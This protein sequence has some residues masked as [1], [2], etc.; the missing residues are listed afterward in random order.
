MQ[1]CL[2]YVTRPELEQ[3]A[4]LCNVHSDVQAMKLSPFMELSDSGSVASSSVSA[5]RRKVYKKRKQEYHQEK[6]RIAYEL[7][8]TLK[9]PTVVI[10]ADWLKIRGTLRKWMRV[11]CVLKPGLFIVYKN[12]KTDKLG[13]WIGTVLLSSCELIERPSKKGGFCFK[14]Y[15]AMDQSIWASRG[16]R[17]ESFG[18]VTQP[19]PTSHLICRA[20]SEESGRCWMDGLELALKCNRLLLRTLSRQLNK[21]NP[22]LD[23][24]TNE[25]KNISDSLVTLDVK[26]DLGK[27]SCYSFSRV[28]L[29]DVANLLEDETPS[30]LEEDVERAIRETP[31]VPAPPE[32]FG[33]F[34]GLEQVEEVAD[35]NKSLLWAL[36]KQVRPGMDLSKVVLPTFVLEPRSFLEKLADYY[37][38]SDLLTEAIRENDPYK[39]IQLVLKFYL[40]GFYKKPKVNHN[41]PFLR[42][43]VRRFVAYLLQGL[44]KPYNPVL[45][46]MFRCYWHSPETG[47]KTFYI[48][49]QVSHHP[50]VSA[51]FVTNR[52]AGFNIAGSILAKSKFYGNSLSAILCGNAKITLLSRGESYVVTLPYAHCKGLLIGTLTFQLGGSVCIT[53]DRTSYSAEL[54]FKLRPFLGG[55]ETINSVV[56]KVKLGKETLADINGRWDSSIHFTDRETGETSVLWA[57]TEE[58]IQQRLQRFDVDFQHQSP[59]ESQKLWMAVSEAIR[60]S[61]QTKATEEKTKIEDAQRQRARELASLGEAYEPHVFEFDSLSGQWLYRHADYRPWDSQNDVVQYESNFVI[62]TQSHHKTP[63]VKTGSLSSVHSPNYN[64]MGAS[65]EWSEEEESASEQSQETEKATA[66]TL[67]RFPI[68]KK[69][70]METLQ[71]AVM[72]I[73]KRL[74][75][76]ELKLDAL[77]RRNGLIVLGGQAV[78]FSLGNWYC[79]H[80]LSVNDETDSRQCE[81]YF[82]GT[83]SLCCNLLLLVIFEILGVLSR[84]S[85]LFFWKATL[86]AVAAMLLFFIPKTV[87]QL[88]IRKLRFTNRT[89]A[90]GL[91]SFIWLSTMYFSWKVLGPLP[92]TR[93]E[94]SIWSIENIVSRVGVIGV[95]IVAALAGFGAIS[96]LYTSLPCFAQKVPEDYADKVERQIGKTIEMIAAKKFGTFS[97]GSINERYRTTQGFL[98]LLGMGT[99]S[100]AE[101]EAFEEVKSLEAFN[102]RLFMELADINAIN[103]R[104]E[105]ARTFRGKY[106]LVLGYLLSLL[107]VWKIFSVRSA[108]SIINIVFDRYG[109]VDPVTRVIGIAVHY[110]GFDFDVKIWSQHFSFV[111][112]GCLSLSSVR[113]LLVSFAKLF[114]IVNPGRLSKIS[115][116]LTAEVMGMYLLS[117]VLLVR[118]S[119]PPEYRWII[120][121]VFGDLAYPF[122][123][124]WFDEIFILSAIASIVF[125]AIVRK[126]YDF[127]KCE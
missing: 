89:F 82:S 13:H 47:S 84:N 116:L 51:F 30:E 98:N 1:S 35:E 68:G 15:H 61:D 100:A 55:T 34:G 11:F 64:T 85:R 14:L 126:K 127:N 113:S 73:T 66:A 52:K 110:M 54:E 18:A 42:L 20:P 95:L 46:E 67:R 62:K 105:Y 36:M 90:N 72:E 58:V 43:R 122:Y 102:E 121:E 21:E 33:E 87:A 92:V 83:F 124:R 88:A 29:N 112:V 8:Q 99:T 91:L 27:L 77:S 19:L 3:Q 60:A 79:R 50:P 16:P 101:K 106:F 2:Q 65:K 32:V 125:F 26:S 24:I 40:S 39:R 41:C 104:K 5:G 22:D 86:Y 123:Q 45:G 17:G 25:E 76:I 74:T 117:T 6:K 38:H 71:E 93:G 115:V 10:I 81:I 69:D 23:E 53:C 37:Y 75:S 119:M 78:F 63:I 7:M 103:Q 118:M 31:Y 109:T 111:F 44:K 108:M 56:G 120:T 49:E 107:S 57:A 4:S 114:S 97:A 59:F 70:G 80:I 9:D 96:C 48:A 12:E 28:R 94:T